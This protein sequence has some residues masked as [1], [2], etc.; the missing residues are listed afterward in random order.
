[1][2]TLCMMA[3]K[4]K[5]Y[6]DVLGVSR[7]ASP[8]EV[9]DAYRKLA[10][11]HHPDL[12]S[13]ESKKKAAEE[14]FKEV[15]EAYEVLGDQEKRKKYDRLGSQ[16]KNGMDFSPPPGGPGYG[17]GGT[18]T[19]SEEF[20]GGFSDFFESIFGGRGG[21][22]E[23]GGTSWDRGTRQEPA[24]AADLEAELELPLEDIAR[25]G[26]RRVTLMARDQQG[27]ARPKELDVTIP[28]GLREGHRMRLKGQ[29][30][31]ARGS[32]RPGDLFLRIHVLP[33]PLFS[34]IEDS[35]DDIQLD[36]PLLPW[37]AVLGTEVDV[38]TLNGPVSMRIPSATQAGQKLRLRGKGLPRRDGKSGDLYARLSLVTPRSISARERELYEE[39]GKL[40]TDNPR[41]ELNAG[42]PTGR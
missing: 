12:Q 24:Q 29:G 14:K 30:A 11:Q 17:S 2:V 38:P 42:R 27:H 35:P 28:I 22:Y 7:E 1:M 34:L 5:D 8:K 3:V 23:R 32:G 6:Y 36:L 37:E 15:N 25:G 26:T 16:Y 39:L 18:W 9:K 13:V 20:S 33:H 41:K 10:R 31:A 19:S 40:S 21:P 4:F